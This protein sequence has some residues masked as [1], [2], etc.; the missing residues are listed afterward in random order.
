MVKAKD[1]ANRVTYSVR[2]NPDVL[3]E[4]KHLAVDE[5]KTVGELIEE[6]IRLVIERRQRA[7]GE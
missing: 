6:G 7:V 4:L 1:G 3:K 2:L 5:N